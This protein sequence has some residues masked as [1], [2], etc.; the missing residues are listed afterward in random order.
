MISNK[1][2]IQLKVSDNLL[3]ATTDS[4]ELLAVQT[5]ETVTEPQR[6]YPLKSIEDYG[7]IGDG[8]T[9]YSDEIKAAIL[10]AASNGYNLYFPSGTYMIGGGE[11]GNISPANGADFIISGD[12]STSILKCIAGT[13]TQ[14]FDGFV[15]FYA[16][17]DT[18]INKIEIRDICFDQNARENP[19]SGSD[20]YEFE[21]SHCLK[22]HAQAKGASVADGYIK[23]VVVRNCTFLDPISQCISIGPSSTFYMVG[24]AQVLNCTFGARNRVQSSVISGGS[25][26]S[27]LIQDC[28]GDDSGSYPSEVQSEFESQP[29]TG[30]NVIKVLNCQFGSLQ[31]GGQDRDRL[32]YNIYDSVFSLATVFTDS[33]INA[34][35]STLGY[36]G[37]DVVFAWTRTNFNFYNCIID[38]WIQSDGDIETLSITKTT[39]VLT[40]TFR[41]CHFKVNESNYSA[42]VSST[43]IDWNTSAAEFDDDITIRNCTFGNGFLNLFDCVGSGF[44]NSLNNTF[45]CLGWVFQIGSFSSF[46]GKVTST[47]DD[48]SS[49]TKT[50]RISSSEPTPSIINLSGGV[51]P[52]LN[53]ESSS[54][55]SVDNT[56]TSTRTITALSAPTGG[57]IAGDTVFVGDSTYQCTVT[58]PTAATWVEL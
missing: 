36:G 58:H 20:P 56:F 17:K 47:N 45:N 37:L 57:G 41:N 33:T 40:K 48:Y 55:S 15:F 25:V 29:A 54:S 44:V 14:N 50:L 4:A 13:V 7:V 30:T 19:L 8:E 26:K 39:E 2:K 28:V 3:N 38:F 18:V 43:M 31:T 46:R 9:D 51:W 11:M 23:N 22:F 6:V 5:N 52:T 34:Y 1:G 16:L 10:D 21:Q 49:A 32:I 35:N 12:G 42:S 24:D 53:W 27:V